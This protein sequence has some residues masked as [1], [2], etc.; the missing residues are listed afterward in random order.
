MAILLIL[1][2]SILVDDLYS[3]LPIRLHVLLAVYL[4]QFDPLT[5]DLVVLQLFFL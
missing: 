3:F 1:P 4:H 2:I 5:V